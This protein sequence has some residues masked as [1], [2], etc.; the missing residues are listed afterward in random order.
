MRKSLKDFLK[1]DRLFLGLS[2]L[3]VLVLGVF[4]YYLGNTHE[5]NCDYY[6][7]HTAEQ[8]YPFVILVPTVL[9]AYTYAKLTLAKFKNPTNAQVFGV[10]LGCAAILA[11]G[12]FIYVFSGFGLFYAKTC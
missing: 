5:P 1:Y 3:F 4:L 11:V 2:V 8:L 12:I 6:Y 9:V 7:L 10:L